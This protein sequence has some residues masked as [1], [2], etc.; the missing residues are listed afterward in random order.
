MCSYGSICHLPISSLNQC[1]L[2]KV[3]T[4]SFCYQDITVVE[5]LFWIYY[6]SSKTSETKEITQHFDICVY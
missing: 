2:W 3:N 5:N 1:Q 4:L 6:L